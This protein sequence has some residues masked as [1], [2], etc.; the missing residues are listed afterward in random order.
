MNILVTGGAGF[1][2]SCFI[3]QELKKGHSI[4]NIDK[5][6]YAG[7]LDNL[8]HI[9]SDR[10]R[11]VRSDIGESKTVSSILDS[12][13]PDAVVNFAAETHVD[14]SIYGP[15]IFFETNVVGTC[16]LLEAVTKWWDKLPSIQQNLFRFMHISTDEVYGSLDRDDTSSTEDSPIAPNSP[17]S[18]SKASSDLLV[19][20]Y[21]KTYGLPT[22]I[23]R[24]TNNYGP[25]QFL[26]ANPPDNH[27]CRISKR[28][29]GLR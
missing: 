23:S 24:C 12:F 10:Y 2:G 5:L 26:K 29:S 22:L 7:N 28:A 27:E 3:D 20:S 8:A 9:R 21:N 15:S 17:Y 18:A 11:F 16:K 6:T 1:I 19:R 13:K 14:R 25:R 4:L